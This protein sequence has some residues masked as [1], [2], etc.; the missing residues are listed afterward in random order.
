MIDDAKYILWSMTIIEETLRKQIEV[1]NELLQRARSIPDGSPSIYVAGFIKYS[2]Q[3]T[4]PLSADTEAWKAETTEILRVIY[5]EKARQVSDFQ[6][7]LHPI[8]H[9]E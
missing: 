5:G 1:A 8:N 6:R 3:F 9:L 7:C 2:E 4:R